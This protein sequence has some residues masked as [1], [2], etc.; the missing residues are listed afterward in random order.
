MNVGSVSN[1]LSKNAARKIVRDA[2]RV[3]RII[4]EEFPS[5]SSSRIQ[6]FKCADANDTF[7][8]YCKAK[9]LQNR[10]IRDE[11]SKLRKTDDA[12]DFFRCFIENMKKYKNINCGDYTKL[13]QLLLKANNVEAVNAAVMTKKL[14]NLDHMVLLVNVPKKA[15]CIVGNNADLKNIIVI[16]PWLRFADFANNAIVR[17]NS[18]FSRCM[19][20]EDKYEKLFFYLWPNPN[21]SDKVIQYIRE[22]FPHFI[23][24]KGF[25]ANV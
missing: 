21:I 19:G 10:Y 14:K 25:M 1:V 6:T 9:L 15:S 5:V 12:L 17:Y 20:L 24:K 3:C 4:A 8:K 22:T 16:D 13:A 11:A 7:I 18:E 23:Q 2:D